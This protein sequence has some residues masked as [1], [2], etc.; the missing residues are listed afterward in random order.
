MKDPA[1][2][3]ILPVYNRAS[4]IGRSIQSVLDQSYEDFELIVVDDCSTDGTDRKVRSYTDPR[5]KYFR[6]DE[7]VSAGAA[8]NFGMRKSSAEFLAFQDSDDEWVADKLDGQVSALRRLASDVGV[9]YSDMERIYGD[10]SSSY[11]MAPDIAGP[12]IVNELTK[13]YSVANIGIQSSVIKKKFIGEAGHF[14][15]A[16]P[17]YEDLEL[18]IRLSRRCRFYHMGKALVRYYETEGISSDL[19]GA[20]LARKMIL[21]IYSKDLVKYK[22]FVAKELHGIEA[23][24]AASKSKER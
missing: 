1:V 21:A 8:R 14:N 5:V 15:E 4:T 3:V 17:A 10:G 22:W 20:A 18:F 13:D 24:L 23:R 12:Q 9:V 11:L 2:S 19:A 7:R 16:L 6:L